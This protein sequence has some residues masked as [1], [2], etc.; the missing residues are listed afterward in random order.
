MRSLTR[1]HTRSV[2]RYATRM[3]GGARRPAPPSLAM[4]C[5]LFEQVIRMHKRL[6]NDLQDPRPVEDLQ[7][8]QQFQAALE[9]VYGV[10]DNGRDLTAQKPSE[11]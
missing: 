1:R 7:L 5:S 6:F 4:V 11:R 10:N 3:V 8:N 9:R 2:W